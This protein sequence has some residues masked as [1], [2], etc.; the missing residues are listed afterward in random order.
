[1]SYAEKNNVFY[2]N[3]NIILIILTF[4]T[5]YVAYFLKINHLKCQSWNV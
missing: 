2:M 5:A 1:M 4:N 3:N